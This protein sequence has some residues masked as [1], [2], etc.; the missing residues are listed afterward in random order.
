[1]I[2]CKS[3]LLDRDG[4]LITDK[5]HIIN[6]LDIFIL[7]GVFEA[8]YYLKKIISKFLLLQINL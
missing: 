8:L 5:K 7:P 1:M 3:F 4:V 2:K 6:K